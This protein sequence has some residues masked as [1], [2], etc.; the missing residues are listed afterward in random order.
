MSEG[1]KIDREGVQDIQ[2][3][4]HARGAVIVCIITCSEL[5]LPSFENPTIEDRCHGINCDRV[6]QGSSACYLLLP[7]N[8][9]SSH[10]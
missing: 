2:K 5:A 1:L 10:V 3:R 9:F 6:Y 8:T 7:Y 4:R